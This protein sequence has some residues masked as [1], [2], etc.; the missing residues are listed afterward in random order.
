[1]YT[2]EGDQSKVDQW[3]QPQLR[4]NASHDANKGADLSSASGNA[5]RME[6][7]A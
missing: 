4:L 1:M 3:N 5:D 7:N 2:F 6:L